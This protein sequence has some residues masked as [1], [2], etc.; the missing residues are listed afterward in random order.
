[1]PT[2]YEAVV[3]DL[4]AFIQGKDGPSFGRRELVDKLLELRVRHRMAEGLPERALRLYGPELTEILRQRSA[5]P[6]PEGPGGMGDDAI[7]RIGATP[8]EGAT[9]V[10]NGHG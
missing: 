1:M 8:H 10:R 2:D 7:H 9:H 5:T 3:Q 4:E 6:G